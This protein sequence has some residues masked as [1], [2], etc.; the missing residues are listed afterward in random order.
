[1]EGQQ[2]PNHPGEVSS[3]ETQPQEPQPPSA[4]GPQPTGSAG[5][6]RARSSPQP[7]QQ[8]RQQQ[9]SPFPQQTF[10]H[11]LGSQPEQPTGATGAAAA[12]AAAAGGPRSATMWASQSTLASGHIDEMAEG[13]EDDRQLLMV[14][15]PKRN[16]RQQEQNKQ[17]RGEAGA[18]ALVQLCP[19]HAVPCI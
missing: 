15:K 18:A 9:G 10:L 17:V 12:A 3:A 14:L 4:S 2:A 7:Q 13:Q 5:S 19:L 8:Q 11:F 6:G 16:A 1:M